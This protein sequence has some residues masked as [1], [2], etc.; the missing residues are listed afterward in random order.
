MVGVKKEK[1]N[2]YIHTRKKI[3]KQKK[4]ENK[5]KTQKKTKNKQTNKTTTRQKHT[6]IQKIVQTSKQKSS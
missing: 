6:Y 4:K 1:K 5:K 3:A 2:I